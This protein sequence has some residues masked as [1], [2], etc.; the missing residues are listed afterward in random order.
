[1]TPKDV[2]LEDA[3]FCF[4][5][6]SDQGVFLKSPDR[7]WGPPVELVCQSNGPG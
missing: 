7:D 4:E 1:M 6:G 5:E 3:L 2:T